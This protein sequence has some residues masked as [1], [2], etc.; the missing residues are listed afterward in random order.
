MFYFICANLKNKKSIKGLESEI[1]TAASLRHPNIVPIYGVAIL[2]NEIWIVME[3]ADGCLYSQ[4]SDSSV[5]LDWPRR[6][7]LAHSAC[8]AVQ[9]LHKRNVC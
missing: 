3:L 1:N 2:P 6:L 9:F 8:L 5:S 4:L 7:S